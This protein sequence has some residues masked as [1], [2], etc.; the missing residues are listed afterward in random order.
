MIAIMT[1][2]SELDEEIKDGLNGSSIISSF[3]EFAQNM[4]NF[5][6]VILRRHQLWTLKALESV[7]KTIKVLGAEIYYIAKTDDTDETKLLIELDI[8]NILFEPIEADKIIGK[9]ESSYIQDIGLFYDDLY[10]EDRL[11]D[12]DDL[13]YEEPVDVVIKEEIEDDIKEDKKTAEIK[14]VETAIVEKAQP[15]VTVKQESTFRFLLNYISKLLGLFVILISTFIEHFMQIV[16]TIIVLFIVNYYIKEQ[17][18]SNFTG[19]MD[20]G[21]EIIQQFAR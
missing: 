12:D 11:F 9:V 14:K 10:Y 8:K 6:K 21:K 5:N 16:I 19:L 17:G 15:V 4:A 3:E 1:W 7:L 20:L 18:I 2:S 13:Y